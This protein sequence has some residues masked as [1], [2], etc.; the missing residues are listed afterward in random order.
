MQISELIRTSAAAAL[1]LT[2]AGSA[3][4]LD[5]QK[6]SAPTAAVVPSKPTEILDAFK[7]QGNVIKKR[8]DTHKMAE[9]NK[10]F[11]HFKW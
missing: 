6:Q 2:C 11:S 4:A 5:P 1:V 9:A 3:I 7:N 8:E 10:A